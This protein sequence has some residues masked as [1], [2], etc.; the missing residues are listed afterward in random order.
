MDFGIIVITLIE[1]LKLLVLVSVLSFIGYKLLSP[2]REKLAEKYN[3]SW[4]K[5]CIIFNI[6][7]LF[8]VILAIYIYFMLVGGLSAPA[9]DPSI[10]YSLIDN[11]L[12]ILIASVRILIASVI[13]GLFLLFFEL[14]ASLFMSG[15]GV[16]NARK[17]KVTNNWVNQFIGIVIASA[18]FLILILFIFD[19]VPLGLFIYVFYGA[20]KPLPLIIG[21]L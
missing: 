2:L 10:E 21:I 16:E 18:V 6:V 17:K 19:W 14:I 9:R 7:F 4:M 3:L 12:F 11:L 1:F 8:V 20:V 13:L 5:S 15:R